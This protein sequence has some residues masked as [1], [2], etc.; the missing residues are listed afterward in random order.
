MYNEFRGILCVLLVSYFYFQF[1]QGF[2]SGF[3]YRS[4]HFKKFLIILV[5]T[6]KR[7][8]I[9]VFHSHKVIP[10]NILFHRILL[11]QYSFWL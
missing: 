7:F 1:F 6:V 2:S 3:Y 8:F 9:N 5:Q 10:I 11:E 4:Q